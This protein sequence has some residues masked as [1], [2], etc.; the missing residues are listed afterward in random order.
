MIK[1]CDRS[2]V[3]SLRSALQGRRCAELSLRYLSREQPWGSYSQGALFPLT[4]A[5]SDSVTLT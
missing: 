3:E 2:E 4:T 1:L 5:G